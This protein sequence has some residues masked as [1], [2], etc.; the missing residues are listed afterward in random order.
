LQAAAAIE[1]LR[2]RL[3][4]IQ[5]MPERGVALSGVVVDPGTSSRE[6][7]ILR[8]LFTIECTHDS[9]RFDKLVV[10]RDGPAGGVALGLQEVFCCAMA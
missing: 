9:R 2:T 4:G 10:T 1:S 3:V 7:C 6:A 8:F 5:E